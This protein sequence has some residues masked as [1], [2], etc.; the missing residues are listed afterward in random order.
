MWFF[1]SDLK[2]Q[3][4]D[5]PAREAQKQ[6]IVRIIS[7]PSANDEL[8]GEDHYA[9]RKT[10]FCLY[11]YD[12]WTYKTSRS[13]S[14]LVQAFGQTGWRHEPYRTYLEKAGEFY[15]PPIDVFM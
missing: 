6:S 4:F 15:Y 9:I 2:A 8:L 12:G 10:N 5:I 13:W 7:M 14:E 11:G 3:L 1:S